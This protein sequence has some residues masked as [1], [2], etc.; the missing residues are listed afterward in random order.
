MV[1]LSSIG[2]FAFVIYIILFLILF[3]II[4]VL[5]LLYKVRRQV[6]KKEREYN[7]NQPNTEKQKDATNTK[8]QAAAKGKI[9]GPNDGEYVEFEEIIE[10]DNKQK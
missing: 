7:S 1:K 3:P 6:K 8:R 10:D 5:R 4:Y 2:C 9:Y